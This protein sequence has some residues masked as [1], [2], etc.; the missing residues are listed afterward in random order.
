[1]R[2]IICIFTASIRF[3][4]AIYI[5]HLKD[6]EFIALLTEIRNLQVKPMVKVGL[7]GFELKDEVNSETLILDVVQLPEIEGEIFC[8]FK[9]NLFRR[10]LQV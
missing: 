7:A 9:L 8:L 6:R 1:M 4:M 10:V 2:R 3:K 5:H